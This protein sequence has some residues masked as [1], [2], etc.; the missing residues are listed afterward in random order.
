MAG[1]PVDTVI[2]APVRAER[3]SRRRSRPILHYLSLLVLVMVVPAL[4]VTLIL[5]QRSNQSQQEVLRGLTEATVQAIGQSVDRELSG[6]I[7]TLRVLGTSQSLLEEDYANFHDRAS[8][9]LDGT[10][11]YLIAIDDSFDQLLNTRRPY[12]TPLGPVGDRP[13]AEQALTAGGGALVSGVFFGSIAQDWVINV[14][15]P[16]PLQVA[17]RILILTQN[18]Q[19]FALALQSR[20]LPQGW[21]AAL[22]D[23]SELVIAATSAAGLQPGTLLPARQILSETQG[24]WRRERFDGRDVVTAQWRS[25]LSGW[26][27][28]AWADTA[29]VDRPLSDTL[30]WLAAWTLLLAIVSLGLALY[31]ARQVGSSV[32]GLRR[33]AQ[34]LGAGQPVQSRAYPVAEIAEVSRSLAD[35][36]R[37]RRAAEAEVNF[38]MR[39]VAHRSKN[40]MT[41]I[42]AMAKQTARGAV[43]VDAYVHNFERRIMGL[44]RSTDLLLAHGSMGVS[45][46]DLMESQLEPFRPPGEGRIRIEGPDI[47]LNMQAAQILGMAAHE[48]ATN[49]VKYGAFSGDDG[50]LALTWTVVDDQLRLVWRETVTTPLVSSDRTGFGTTVLKSM[51][52]RS[53]GAGVERTT[54]ADGIEW[55]FDIPL[56]V[57]AP[58]RESTADE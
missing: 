46:R 39:E 5:L 10:G 4:V 50:R 16:V 2:T 47:R 26:H 13:S 3:R 54:H 18:A 55:R 32:R 37:Q 34:L 7:T 41:V 36:S 8:A 57:L 15:V 42:A 14:L 31:I 28:I 12:G 22:V 9:A 38:L 25:A 21:N 20:Q 44:A 48:L 33:D 43:D 30:I 49:A 6:M 51:V 27:L 52:G 23:G 17:T 53:L 29:T 19:N 35:A 11:A 24:E 1:E 56:A 58:D 40:Q 45:L